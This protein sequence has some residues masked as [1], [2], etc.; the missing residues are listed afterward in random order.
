MTVPKSLIEIQ[1]PGIVKNFW[2][3]KNLED[4]TSQFQNLPQSSDNQ[5]SESGISVR[6]SEINTYIS[7]EFIF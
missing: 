4:S 6:E 2:K 7:D 1:G 5:D 3:T